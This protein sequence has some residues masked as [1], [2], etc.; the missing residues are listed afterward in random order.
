MVSMIRAL[1]A[2][3]L[4]MKRTLALWLAII[5]PAVIVGLQFADVFMRGQYYL[6]EG[7]NP[8]PWLARRTLG[9]WALLMHPLF[10]ALETALLASLEHRNNHWKHLFALPVPR[11][12]IYVAKQITGM[13]LIG[14]SL[15]A[16][17]AFTVAAGFVLRFIRPGLHFGNDVPWQQILGQSGRI[18]LAS[19]LIISLHT[20]VATRFKS[21]TLALGFGIAMTII[22]FMVI[23]ADWGR[24]YP[25][26]L[27]LIVSDA[28]GKDAQPIAELMMGSIGGVIVAV[29]GGW[30]CIR[31]DVL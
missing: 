6:T 1:G 17:S 24:F 5:A 9:F 29:L 28:F 20:W 26:A 18:F 21:F 4:K 13:A 22:G 14:L 8:W 31:R 12:A 23:L 15:V 30:E 3:R 11:W 25:W 7:M 19:W 27:P 2:E 16:L 10:V